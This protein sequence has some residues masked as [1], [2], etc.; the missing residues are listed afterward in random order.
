MRFDTRSKR[1]VVPKGAATKSIK[2]V[3]SSRSEVE[4]DLEN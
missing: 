1:K 3:G 4:A 2:E